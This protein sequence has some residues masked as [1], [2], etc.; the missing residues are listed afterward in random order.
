MYTLLGYGDMIADKVRTDV[1]SRAI[2]QI[3]KPGFVVLEIGTGPG[4]FAILACQ[5][6]AS[7]VFAIESS[8]VIQVAREAAIANGCADRIEFFEG[9]STLVTLPARADVIFSDL[10]GVLPLLGH[11]IPSI[12]DARNRFLKPGGVFCPRKDTIWMA[13]VETPKIYSRIVDPWEQ[14]GLDQN[15]ASARR[16]AVNN[17]MRARATPDQLL[18]EPQ[19]WATVNYS[20]IES[21]DAR[22]TLQWTVKR[23]GTG[24]GILLWFDADLAESTEFST[25]PFGPETIYSSMF[26]PWIRPVTLAQGDAVCVQMEAK[27]AGDD[28][29]WRWD[30]QVKPSDLR[31]KT[32]EDFQQST[33][34]GLVLSPVQLRKGASDH[35]PLLSDEGVMARRV[36]ER[37]DG[38]AT[39]EQIA[40]T[41]AAEYPERFAG[42]HDA[43]KF[44]G[45]L[46]QKYSL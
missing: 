41:L 17:L 2:R 44:A 10:R 16:R 12:V 6:G 13:V 29:V 4:V 43:M 18:T 20:S 40:R 31:G 42:W 8:D 26:F 45:D 27:L 19:L 33:L 9:L 39:L 32:R 46:S 21:P 37:V 15:L 36:L 22:G 35:V 7:R 25:S 34:S 11:H 14:S 30:T 38:R 1:Y 3:V 24:H 28:Y 5:A 23:A